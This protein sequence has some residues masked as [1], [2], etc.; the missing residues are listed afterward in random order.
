MTPVQVAGHPARH[1]PSVP[2]SLRVSLAA[3]GGHG[4][5]VPDTEVSPPGEVVPHVDPVPGPYCR[6]LP[7]PGHLQQVPLPLDHVGLAPDVIARQPV[8]G[9]A[10]KLIG[11]SNLRVGVPV[12][13]QGEGI[14]VVESP[15][16]DPSSD[17]GRHAGNVLPPLG[18]IRPLLDVVCVVRS[19]H[20]AGSVHL[21]GQLPHLGPVKQNYSGVK[22]QVFKIIGL[23]EVEVWV[24]ISVSI[25][26]NLVVWY[27]QIQSC[28]V[29]PQDD[30]V[31]SEQQR[32]P[33]AH[34]EVSPREPLRV[35]WQEVISSI[36]IQCPDYA[37]EVC[38]K[39]QSLCRFHISRPDSEERHNSPEL[40]L[41]VLQVVLEVARVR[42]LQ[43]FSHGVH[44]A[45]RL[46]ILWIHVSKSIH[47]VLDQVTG[48]K[49][50]SY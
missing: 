11:G 26:V 34:E 8:V 42:L 19:L 32:G 30:F 27:Q 24:G 50:K 45:L 18:Q 6:P 25:R 46:C 4:A 9:E 39:A 7:A 33:L 40:V 2:L 22:L 20:P 23:Q 43:H 14:P 31:R 13:P 16:I 44:N 28:P 15:V 12:N 48:I 47:D 29:Y 3:A 36:L 41:R 38:S 21:A 5:A 37:I 17:Q 10:G 1:Q 49:C 35:S